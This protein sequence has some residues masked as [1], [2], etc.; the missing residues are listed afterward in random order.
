[1]RLWT[2]NV[3]S[4]QVMA[5]SDPLPEVRS[6]RMILAIEVTNVGM[7][8]TAQETVPAQPEHSETLIMTR[9]LVS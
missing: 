5:R 7:I 3:C 6:L 4:P 2:W 9:G 8:H 1:M